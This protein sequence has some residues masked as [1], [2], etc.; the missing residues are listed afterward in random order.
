M[1]GTGDKDDSAGVAVES[2]DDAGSSR[3]ADRAERFK[4]VRQRG[5]ERAG[6]MAFG[7]VD[8]HVRRFV[9]SN[10]V[11]VFKQDVQRDCL[12][13]RRLGGSLGGAET[14]GLIGLESQ[15]RL[16]FLIVH[17]H[18]TS[19][20]RALEF[21]AAKATEVFDQKRIEPLSVLG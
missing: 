11:F 9:D 1:I 16:R 12:R 10:E 19:R 17:Q 3:S 21:D 14:N 15:G 5:S 6:P 8:D 2:V 4:V 20:N 18:S 7:W 13:D